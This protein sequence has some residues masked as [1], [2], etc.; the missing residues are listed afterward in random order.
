MTR[1]LLLWLFTAAAVSA[2][3]TD[4]RLQKEIDKLT[5]GF[6]GTIGVYVKDLKTG[7]TAS[8]LA[9]TVFPTA[10][11][12]KVP[13]LLGVM[14][15]IEKGQLGYHQNVVLTD[16][17]RYPGSDEAD[18]VNAMKTSE[19]IEISRLILLMLSTSDNTASLWL[20]GLAGGGLRINAILDSLG[21]AQTRVNSRTPGRQHIRNRIG[22]GQTTPREMATLF[23]QIAAGKVFSRSA[24]EK[25]LRLLGRQYWDQYALSQI[26]PDVFAADKHGCVNKSR[27]EVVYVAGDHPYVFAVFTQNNQDE[28][29]EPSN[30][31]WTVTR[32]LSALL[33]KYY[34]PKSTWV[35]DT[36]NW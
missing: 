16:S 29:W 11:I 28:S 35:P 24:S 10:S 9:D 6:H 19:K 3:K 34:H 12:V 30:E 13:I 32:K 22:W 26:P 36:K 27:S 5:T 31:A 17:L 21:Y 25:M 18:L 4:T 33:W 2:Q 20:Q 1:I 23:E 15:K 14:D 8:V 7:Q